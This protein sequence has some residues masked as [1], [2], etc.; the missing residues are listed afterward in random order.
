MS[1]VNTV[2]IGNENL[3]AFISISDL[4][5]TSTALDVS[6]TLAIFGEVNS[7]EVY[8]LQNSKGELQAFA[9]VRFSEE[10]S[11][12][13]ASLEKKIAI[14]GKTV[15]L[16]LTET[17]YMNGEDSSDEEEEEV[18]WDYSSNN[19]AEYEENISKTA[20]LE[21]GLDEEEIQIWP[22]LNLQEIEIGVEGNF[23]PTFRKEHQ[24]V[25][26]NLRFNK[27]PN[28]GPKL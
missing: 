10:E 6:Q 26:Y 4:S 3:P 17:S 5:L 11:T 27:R 18:Y 23:I 15:E 8:T 28:N 2:N 12:I 7:A 19:H 9:E 22:W 21:Q 16:C 14:N 13:K 1:L 20:D 25:D 24:H